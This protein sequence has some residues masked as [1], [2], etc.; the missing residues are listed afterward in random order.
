MQMYWLLFTKSIRYCRFKY[1]YSK[2]IYKKWDGF[3]NK[4]YSDEFSTLWI[5]LCH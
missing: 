5:I 4:I 2:I 1:L 3:E